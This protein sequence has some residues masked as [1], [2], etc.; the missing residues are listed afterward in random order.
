MSLHSPMSKPFSKILLIICNPLQYMASPICL[1]NL[2]FSDLSMN[3]EPTF[4]CIVSF[5]RKE[6][7]PSIVQQFHF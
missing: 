2:D 5:I 7:I 4:Y 1:G 6:E 3:K